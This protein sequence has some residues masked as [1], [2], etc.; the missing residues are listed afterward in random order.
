MSFSGAELI[1]EWALNIWR[2]DRTSGDKRTEKRNLKKRNR[3]TR[4]FLLEV[5]CGTELRA[6]SLHGPTHQVSLQEPSTHTLVKQQHGAHHLCL[7]AIYLRVCGSAGSPQHCH[8]LLAEL[9]LTGSHVH[10]CHFGCLRETEQE[11]EQ[12]GKRKPS[13]TIR[14]S[15]CVYWQVSLCSPLRR[16]PAGPGGRQRLCV[17]KQRHSQHLTSE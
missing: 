1:T 15:V 12:A 13:K 17:L 16:D 7:C 14:R 3:T 9:V 11:R 6:G 8:L 5:L 2:L 10:R 4:C